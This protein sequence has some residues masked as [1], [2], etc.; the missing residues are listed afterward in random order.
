MSQSQASFRS[1]NYTKQSWEVV[2]KR[3]EKQGF[4]PQ[5]FE[6]MAT[7]KVVI[8]PMF[9][10]YGGGVAKD[11]SNITHGDLTSSQEKN[12]KHK[13][14]EEERL[15]AKQEL[16]KAIVE[17]F[18]KGRESGIKQ[19]QEQGQNKLEEVQK[20]SSQLISQLNGEFNKQLKTIS[21]LATSLALEVSKKIIDYAV[22]IN[23]EYLTQIIKHGVSLA[24]SAQ[25]KSIRVSQED[26]EFLTVIGKK[27][28]VGEEIAKIEF[29]PDAD[30]K[31]GCLI[32]SSAGV[33][34]YRLDQ[35]FERIKDELV[36]KSD[37]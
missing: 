31:S 25:I 34:D 17:A 15:R 22:E 23:P 32:E 20:R 11:Q 21:D 33:V 18:N 19:G 6:V 26:H 7:R 13:Q 5:N 24:G 10:D 27:E 37:L 16:E 14:L 3:I 4:L 1:S 9:R 30:L 36:R 8:D 12:N 29:V 35:A 2:G 28:L